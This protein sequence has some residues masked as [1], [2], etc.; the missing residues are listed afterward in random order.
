VNFE[1]GM[2]GG[3]LEDLLLLAEEDLEEEAALD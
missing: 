3:V 1:V 2:G